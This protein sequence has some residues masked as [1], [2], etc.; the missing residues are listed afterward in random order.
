MALA[1]LPI[2]IE[3]PEMTAQEIQDLVVGERM[4]SKVLYADLIDRTPPLLAL[5]DG[6]VDLLFGRSLVA[7]HILALVLL[8]FQA[9]YFGI[10]L[11]NNR[12]Y[13]ENTYVPS[14]I[15][16]LLF[17]FSFDVVSLTPE[18]L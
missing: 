17:F 11:I 18:L 8:F 4:M 15:A 3:V 9:A 6:V 7:R 5:I 10:L 2:W 14:L 16:G 13:N 12:A 1:S